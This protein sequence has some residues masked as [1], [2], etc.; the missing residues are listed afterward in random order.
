MK[1]K[2]SCIALSLALAISFVPISSANEYVEEKLPN[3]TQDTQEQQNI[4][5]EQFA[6]EE[7][8]TVKVSTE[9]ELEAQLK[10]KA[11]HITITSSF[12]ITK[13][14][15]ITSS[16]TIVGEGDVTLTVPK[17]VT[18]YSEGIFY[19]TDSVEEINIENVNFKRGD[20]TEDSHRNRLFYIK[21]D[22]INV[23]LKKCNMS[24]FRSSMGTVIRLQEKTKGKKDNRLNISLENCL[25]E[26]NTTTSSD[27]AGILV[28]GPSDIVVKNST[29]KNNKSSSYSGAIRQSAAL[30]TDQEG[31]SV[32]MYIS[33]STFEGNSSENVGGAIDG[34]YSKSVPT[35]NIDGSTFKS[36]VANSSGGLGGAINL[37][38][39]NELGTLNIKNSILSENMSNNAHGGALR[40]NGFDIKLE[41]NTF[42]NNSAKTQ[43]GA[44]A[45]SSSDNIKTYKSSNNKFI[46]NKSFGLNWSSDGGA[47]LTTGLI[48]TYIDN[49][50]YIGNTSIAGGGAISAYTNVFGKDLDT[51]FEIKNSLFEKNKS[52]G[53]PE[54]TDTQ[55]FG[56][57]ALIHGDMKTTIE[58]TK[59]IENEASK[60][61]GIFYYDSTTQNRGSLYFSGV[62]FDKNK[63]TN[64]GGAVVI[65]N[66]SDLTTEFNNTKFRENS[67]ANNTA[68]ALYVRVPVKSGVAVTSNVKVKN[69]EFIKNSTSG[70]GG[71]IYSYVFNYEEDKK[72]LEDGQMV[73]L[74]I[75]GS[76]FEE[77]T[78]GISAGAIYADANTTANITSTDFSKNKSDKYGGAIGIES[79]KDIN[80]KES[81]FDSN[82]TGIL[83]GA[84]NVL[85]MEDRLT[86]DADSVYYSPLKVSNTKF[87]GNIA[88]KGIFELDKSKYPE[89]YKIY[90]SNIKGLTALS[91]PADVS[92][93]LAYNN[94]DISF[95]SDKVLKPED[96]E[97]PGGGGGGGTT[98]PTKRATAVL[99]NGKKYTDV[100]TATVLAN[101]R[102]CPILLT[103]TNDI[104]T[105]TFNE[106]KRRGIG[107]VIISGGPDSVSQKVVDQLK[108]F[109][110]IRYAGSDR[111]G[112]ARE[113]GKEVRA[114]TGKTDGA[115]LVD[116]TNF[117]DVITI[118]A[119]AT[120]KRVPILITNPNKLT[121]TTE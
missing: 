89:V 18:N 38:S 57:A 27:S 37:D 70:Y 79:K 65:Q 46:G 41:G 8:N 22:K 16:V 91:K 51:V 76:K 47:I 45:V 42:E 114:L 88:D 81:T 104:T 1:K 90:Q 10:A 78:A 94:Y 101:E 84:I 35:I 24:G 13:R 111:Y 30:S 96:P 14:M 116:G 109:N 119:L 82:K 69:S 95:V 120:Q 72:D 20:F 58:D 7:V 68:G 83:G 4:K 12:D 105:E 67:S 34:K 3:N 23:T 106:L 110:V 17:A 26:N 103:D 117:P 62:E 31:D 61:G 107:D 11:P 108:D 21:S 25:I 112:T 40:I 44:V 93:H 39:K 97:V 92:K 2:L 77:N 115:M 121:T 99:A 6:Q 63:A 87:T 66:Q 32:L 9:D 59:F 48:N 29:F 102:D 73:K 55:N 118:S 54:D 43:G 49:D 52:L 86:L 5:G 71:G 33:N 56:G 36:N 19:S 15:N 75:E 28:E 85:P 74:D 100:L 50:E 60:G 98:P 53:D 113:I 80:V 64:Y